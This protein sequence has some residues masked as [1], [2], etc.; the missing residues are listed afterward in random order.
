[1]SSLFKTLHV[2]PDSEL[3][4]ALSEAATTGASVLIDTGEAR[5]TI[6]VDV[7]EGLAAAQT[8]RDRPSPEQVARSIEG[9][10]QSAGSWAD[11]DAEAF[12]AY[13]RERRRSS[14]RPHV[15]LD[16]DRSR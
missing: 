5:F 15:R 16:T 14:S 1:M 12:K 13:I 3:G 7:P 11:M 8:D 6:A 10:R 9:I 2:A 4:V